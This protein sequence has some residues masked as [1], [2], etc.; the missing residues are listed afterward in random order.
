MLGA[1]SNYEMDRIDLTVKTTLDFKTQQGVT[2]ELRS[3]NQSAEANPS[4]F[5]AKKC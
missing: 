1:K 4:A 2:A 3:L 5:S